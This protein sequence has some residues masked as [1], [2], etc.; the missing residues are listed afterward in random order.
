MPETEAPETESEYEEPVYA[1][2]SYSVEDRWETVWATETVNVRSDAGSDA[3]KVGS[4]SKG[5]SVTRTGACSNGWSRV[6]Y[7]GT[8]A[9]IH[10]DYLSTEEPVVE[11]P[12]YNAGIGQQIAD[13]AVQFVGNPYVWGG[14]SLTSGA[15]C[16]GFV[17]SIYKAF[18]YSLPRTCTPQMRAGT[19][20][21]ISSLQPGDLVG[22]GSYD[23][24]HHIAIYIGN[25]QIVHASDY[26]T[27]TIISSLYYCGTPARA[28]RIAY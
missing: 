26:S 22:Y 8:T 9:Y 13:Y 27:G 18:G 17:M 16:S 4:L 23:N 2:P 5:S 3:S 11:E 28:T 6:E 19:D 15:D 25:G 1:A 14:T 10:S 12:S 24:L 7:N 21:S 20:I